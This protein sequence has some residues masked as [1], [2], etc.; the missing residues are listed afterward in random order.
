M[1]PIN[2][3]KIVIANNSANFKSIPISIPGTLQPNSVVIVPYK[4]EGQEKGSKQPQTGN[5]VIDGKA[6]TCTAPI[7]NTYRVCVLN[8][9]K[10]EANKS[11]KAE[12]VLGNMDDQQ[13]KLKKL[14]PQNS[15]TRITEGDLGILGYERQSFFD[16]KDPKKE[17]GSVYTTNKGY[18][19]ITIGALNEEGAKTYHD[20]DGD[21]KIDKTELDLGYVETRIGSKTHTNHHVLVRDKENFFIKE[22]TSKDW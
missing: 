10:T 16:A 14:I 18:K 13:E 3:T 21:G 1:A 11:E 9:S 17:I 5:T 22:G 7:M 15:I 2:E 8:P 19:A 20:Y 6:Y 12:M 4:K